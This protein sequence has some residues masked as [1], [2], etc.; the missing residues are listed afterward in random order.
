MKGSTVVFARTLA[1]AAGYELSDDGAMRSG[2]RVVHHVR[3]TEDGFVPHADYVALFD[4]LSRNV[5]DLPGLV[6]AY[7]KS[8]NL[9]AVGALGLA[10]KT[11]PRLRDSLKRFERY[12]RLVTNS[13]EYRLIENG[14]EAVFQLENDF[15]GGPAA[16]LRIE[17]GIAGF[18]MSIERFVGPSLELSEVRFCHPCLGDAK[19][20]A[21]FFGCPTRFGAHHDAIVFAPG[22]LDLP[23]QLGDPAVSDFIIAHLETALAALTPKDTLEA[24]LHRHLSRALST[25]VPPAAGVARELGM[26]ERTFYRRLSASGL[27]YQGVVQQV[28]KGLAE[29]LLSRNACTIAEVAFLTGFSEQ[30]TFSRAFKRWVGTPPAIFRRQSQV[31]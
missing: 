31:A 3:Q 5:D 29:E 14:D 6:F 19:R 2:G 18:R 21:D 10:F 9:D 17:G 11:A 4:W 8:I 24:E 22:M 15:P 13:M 16:D 30:A 1:E 20:Y 27:T 26:S 23:N 25:G 28:Q 7:G 12:G